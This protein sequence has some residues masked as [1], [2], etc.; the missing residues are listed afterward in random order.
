MTDFTSTSSISMSIFTGLISNPAVTFTLQSDTVTDYTSSVTVSG[1]TYSSS[2]QYI[3]DY[4]IQTNNQNY[5]LLESTSKTLTQNLTCS[6]SGSTSITYSIINYIS[7]APSWITINPISGLLIITSPSVASDTTYSFYISSSISG[8]SSPVQ[9][10]MSVTVLNWAVDFWTTWSS[11]AT[12]CAIWNTGYNLSTTGIC[13][14]Q[15]NSTSASTHSSSGSTQEVSRSAKIQAI[16]IFST[17]SLSAIIISI[18]GFANTSS[19]SSLWSMFNQIQIL[20]LLL[21]NR[22]NLPE[23]A[24]TVIAGFKFFSNP[25]LSIPFQE[26]PFYQWAF[27]KFDSSWSNPD[28]ETFGLKSDSSVPNTG[29]FF[30]LFVVLIILHIFVKLLKKLIECWCTWNIWGCPRKVSEWIIDKCL[31]IMTYGY[32]IRFVMQMN[33]FL[34]VASIYEIYNLKL[35]NVFNFIS[36]IFALLVLLFCLCYTWVVLYL[37]LSSYKMTEEGRNKIGEFFMGIKME[38]KYKFFVTVLIL[39]RT[40]FIVLIIYLMSISSRFLVV[41]LS[42]IQL[43][44][45]LYVIFIRPYI[46]VKGNMIEIINEIYFLLLLSYLLFWNRE[47]EWTP[48]LTSIYCYLITSNSIVNFIIIMSK[49]Y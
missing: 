41:I 49:Y 30:I 36:F 2:A 37:S 46:Q 20:F 6:F 28:F 12:V 42:S 47:S 26:I 21:L 16:I 17:I 32:Y 24:K 14:I 44:Y 40:F 31:A 15:S 38:K 43:A 1:V 34:L 4:C 13:S 35:S 27:R 19:L 22:A 10:L 45:L 25:S 29:S 5:S 11:S 39:R 7:S 33:Q 48:L 18:S 23:D 9:M 8:V 3:S